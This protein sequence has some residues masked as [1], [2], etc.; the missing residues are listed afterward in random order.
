MRMMNMFQQQNNQSLAEMNNAHLLALAQQGNASLSHAAL[1]E[2]TTA[3][4]AMREA[5]TNANIEVPKV[6]FYPSRHPD[7]N[8]ARR[9][10]IKQAYKLLT[11]A[12]RSIVNPVRWLFGR[13]YAYNKQTNVC[14]VDGCDCAALIQHDNLY[15]KIS[16]E[17]SGRSLWEMYWQNPVTGQPE[18]F[19]A[20]EKVTSGQ[21][22]RGTYCPEHMHLYHLLCKWE[23]EEEKINQ[24]NPKRLRDR[25]KKGVSIVTVPVAAVAKKDP[26]PAM[27]QKYEPFFAELEKDARRTNGINIIY[28][29]NPV[30]K[31]NDITT[32]V[33]DLRIF[34][35]EIALMNQPTPAFQSILEQQVNQVV[36]QNPHLEETVG[37]G[38]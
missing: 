12:K 25:V 34:K 10:D 38:E 5:S 18:A 33:F 1:M 22:M 28:Y 37:V 20:R 21:K 7:P 15:A 9:K 31:E 16:D 30:T 17:D 23:A 32:V 11:P 2:Q 4:A 8:K 27:L 13:K 26:T 35:Q 6:N 19:V 36:Q 29:T 3:Q 14:V 24:A